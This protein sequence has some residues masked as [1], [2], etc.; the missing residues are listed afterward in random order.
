MT[1]TTN[2]FCPVR[3]LGLMDMQQG[4]TFPHQS[5]TV[6]LD[7]SHALLDENL[8]QA[9]VKAEI[10]TP[11]LDPKIANLFDAYNVR[12][13]VAATFSLM[14]FKDTRTPCENMQADTIEQVLNSGNPYFFEVHYFDNGEKTTTRIP[15]A[16]LDVDDAVKQ[17]MLFTV[18]K[19]HYLPPLTLV[20]ALHQVR[21]TKN[22]EAYHV[23]ELQ[24]LATVRQAESG[25]GILPY[26]AILQDT[27]GNIKESEYFRADSL[28]NAINVAQV[29]FAGYEVLG[30]QL[31]I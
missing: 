17:K 21:A 5:L 15:V 16:E 28:I 29:R 13:G 22:R 27:K 25:K 11:F 2:K 9:D 31:V 1:T 14:L 10:F 19:D 3:F 7:Y 6:E 18:L 4:T 20:S 12:I 26:K 30:A 24:H 23:S 8:T